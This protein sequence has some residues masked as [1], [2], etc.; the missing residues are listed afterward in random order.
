LER[1]IVCIGGHDLL[2]DIIGDM[3]LLSASHVGSMAGLMALKNGEA[4]IA[5][6]HLVDEDTGVYNISIIKKLFAGE[7]MALI[8]GIG[9]I[10]GIMVKKGNPLNIQGLNDLTNPNIRYINRQRGAGTRVLLDYKLK[11]EG[12]DP[13]KIEGYDR[14]A[15]THMAVAAAVAGGSADCGMGIMSAAIAMGLDFITIDNEEWDFALSRKFLELEHIQA[16]IALLKSPELHKKLV[17]LGDYNIER[18]GEVVLID[19]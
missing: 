3:L 10:Q 14:E 2:L 19:C 6:I 13:E 15:T 18:C 4:H 11:C 12:I 7:E 5:P 9:R 16:L 1:T 17:A 8:K